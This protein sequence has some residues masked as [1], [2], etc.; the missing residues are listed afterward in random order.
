MKR[1]FLVTLDMPPRASI[2]KV[3]DYIASAITEFP[4]YTQRNQPDINPDV[5]V[6]VEYLDA[7]AKKRLHKGKS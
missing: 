5:D 1:Q 3:V 2:Q 7:A 6:T 4:D